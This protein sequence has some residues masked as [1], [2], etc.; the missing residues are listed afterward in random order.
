MKPSNP[1]ALL[2]PQEGPMLQYSVVDETGPRPAYATDGAV[3]FDLGTRERVTI[4]PHQ[5]ARLPTNLI[6]DVPEGYALVVSLR[7]GTPPSHGLI[8][9]HGI[10]IIDRDFC[11]AEDE[12]MVQVLNFT[13]L[14]V[15]V[16]RNSRIAQG[17]IVRC[18]RL[19]LIQI[20][21]N[22]GVSRGGFGST[23]I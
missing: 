13:D 20:D 16:E 21:G 18:D 3:A 6:V 11:G 15:T 17:M 10:G 19:P 22:R 23:G 8:M 12:V 4:P 2:P 9:P 7:S 1:Q 5:I 14:P